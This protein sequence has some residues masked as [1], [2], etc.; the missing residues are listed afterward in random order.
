MYYIS[1]IFDKSTKSKYYNHIFEI[2]MNI[3]FTSRIISYI[4]YIHSYVYKQ[5]QI[6]NLK[7]NIDKYNIIFI[8][9]TNKI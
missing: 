9:I 2:N 1:N 4:H 8:Q 3:L 7:Y 6:N 5:S